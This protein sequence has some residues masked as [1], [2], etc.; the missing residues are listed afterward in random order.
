MGGQIYLT[1]FNQNKILHNRLNVEDMRIQ[2]SFI[3]PDIKEIYRIVKTVTV[4]SLIFFLWDGKYNYSSLKK[5][6]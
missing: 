2:L 5:K 6:M 1:Y 4:F 3:K